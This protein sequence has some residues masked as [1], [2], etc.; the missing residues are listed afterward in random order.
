MQLLKNFRNKIAAR[1]FHVK[2]ARKCLAVP[3]SEHK[4][5]TVQT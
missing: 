5:V 4:I 3:T 1:V 2:G